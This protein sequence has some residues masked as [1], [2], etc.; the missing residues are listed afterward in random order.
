MIW[1]LFISVT[2]TMAMLFG[3]VSLVLHW[4]IFIRSIQ[5]NNKWCTDVRLTLIWQQLSHR[6]TIGPNETPSSLCYI[7]SIYNFRWVSLK[8]HTMYTQ[9]EMIELM[10][11][12][13]YPVR[14]NAHAK[15]RMVFWRTNWLTGWLTDCGAYTIWLRIFYSL[16][17]VRCMSGVLNH[18]TVYAHWIY[19]VWTIHRKKLPS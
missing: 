2:C 9:N 3:W 4:S 15:N 16:Q 17:T 12:E 13:L 6:A 7:Y 18:C 19:S 10:K 5:R 14:V 1:L 11:V 8:E